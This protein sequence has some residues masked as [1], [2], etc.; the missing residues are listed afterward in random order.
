MSSRL[1][2]LFFV[3]LTAALGGCA[4]ETSTGS[5][6]KDLTEDQSAASSAKDPKAKAPLGASEGQA[7]GGKGAIECGPGLECKLSD[8]SKSDSAGTCIAGV[9]TCLAMPACDPGHEQVS[10]EAACAKGA[11]AVC[12]SRTL[13]KKTVWCTAALSPGE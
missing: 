2:L 8:P 7:C 10:S 3:T 13:C 5:N 12:Y 4:S 6:D 11:G 9:V 1:S